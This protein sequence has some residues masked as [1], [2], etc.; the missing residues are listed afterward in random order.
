MK[1][2]AIRGS[3]CLIAWCINFIIVGI[4]ASIFLLC[5]KNLGG[6]YTWFVMNI[7]GTILVVSVTHFYDKTNKDWFLIEEIKK[8]KR[9]GIIGMLILWL[10]KQHPM[11]LIPILTLK[12]NP[13]LVTIISRK[14]GKKGL[15][16][17][18]W[19]NLAVSIIS[20]NTILTILIKTGFSIAPY[21]LKK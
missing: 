13:F 17:D 11:I 6:P 14:Y 9:G 15:G 16:R 21:F 18:D 5:F 2:I 12:L 10:S 20:F 7:F 3:L 4:Y 8:K 1:N 19:R